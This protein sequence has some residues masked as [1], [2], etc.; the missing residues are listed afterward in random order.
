LDRCLVN[1]DWCAAFPVSN[2]YNMQI[3][4]KLSDHAA[5]LISTD[6]HLRKVKR[7]FKFEN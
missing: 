3:I 5:I 6:G 7:A 2:V 4:H 1:A